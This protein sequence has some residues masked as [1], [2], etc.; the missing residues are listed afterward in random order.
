MTEAQDKARK[1]QHEADVLAHIAA[2]KAKGET[3]AV[4]KHMKAP[5]HKAIVEAATEAESLA[6]VAAVEAETA[7]IEAAT[8]DLQGVIAGLDAEE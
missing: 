1:T 2:H 8:A 5:A 3:A 6:A 4:A 7:K